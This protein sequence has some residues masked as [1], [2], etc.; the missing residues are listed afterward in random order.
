MMTFLVEKSQ[1]ESFCASVPC[2]TLIVLAETR[3]PF[4]VFKVQ[5]DN[6]IA[7]ICGLLKF[8]GDLHPKSLTQPIQ[9]GFLPIENI[10]ALF[11]NSC[12]RVALR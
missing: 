3:E 9:L 10:K 5:Q 8:P 7:K 2:Q 6:H 11:G 4:V 12:A 1:F